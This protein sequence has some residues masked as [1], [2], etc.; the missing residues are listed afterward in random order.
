MSRDIENLKD[1][2][3]RLTR[4]TETLNTNVT[5]QAAE[6]QVLSERIQDP[7]LAHASERKA[8]PKYLTRQK[9]FQNL[10]TYN[11]GSSSQWE[12]WRFG[13][14]TWIQQEYPRHPG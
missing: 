6:M 7:Q 1:E 14:M 5:W 12:E 10:N 4:V 11:G 9:G 13:V 8:E 3:G 2:F